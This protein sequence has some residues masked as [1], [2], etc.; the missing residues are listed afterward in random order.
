MKGRELFRCGAV[1]EGLEILGALAAELP[2]DREVSELFGTRLYLAT[3]DWKRGTDL[4]L[5]DATRILYRPDSARVAAAKIQA[6]AG[7]HGLLR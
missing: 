3:G 1:Q 5:R 7:W 4:V 2:L 6:L